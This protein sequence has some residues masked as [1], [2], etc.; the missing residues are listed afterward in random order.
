MPKRYLDS[1]DIKTACNL[2]SSMTVQRRS[3]VSYGR[4][5]MM[6]SITI[7][8]DRDSK[9]IVFTGEN[10]SQVLQ[11][12]NYI[13]RLSS[14]I[15][16]NSEECTNLLEIYKFFPKIQEMHVVF[17]VGIYFNISSIGHIS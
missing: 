7:Y 16:N 14:Y 17:D 3:L 10:Y 12:G 1:D 6:M 13:S 15:Y 5:D 4:Y 8:G 11:T 9:P 2:P